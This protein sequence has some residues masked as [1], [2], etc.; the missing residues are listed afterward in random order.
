MRKL[1]LFTLLAVLVGGGAALAMTL[2]EALAY[3]PGNDIMIPYSDEGKE[4]L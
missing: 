3:F 2:D 1:L 4:T